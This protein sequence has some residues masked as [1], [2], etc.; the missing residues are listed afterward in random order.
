MGNSESSI[1]HWSVPCQARIDLAFAPLSPSHRA[2]VGYLRKSVALG[3]VA[4]KA[5]VYP[6]LIP[7]SWAAS[8]SLKWKVGHISTSII[9]TT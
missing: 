5:E 9:S 7:C 2:D 4:L 8:P 6:D 1:S 3:Q